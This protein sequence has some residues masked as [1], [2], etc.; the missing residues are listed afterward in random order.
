MAG[1]IFHS[2][3]SGHLFIAVKNTIYKLAAFGGIYMS[4]IVFYKLAAFGGIYIVILYFINPPQ[5]AAFLITNNLNISLLFSMLLNC[6]LIAS[7]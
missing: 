2:Q 6:F 1:K 3:N 4:N 7:N 5:S